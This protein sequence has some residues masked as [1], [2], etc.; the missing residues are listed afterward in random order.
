MKE[1]QAQKLKNEIILDVMSLI[2]ERNSII[3]NRTVDNLKE[4]AK[5]YSTNLKRASKNETILSIKTALKQFIRNAE[6]YP[7]TINQLY[8][9][10]I[11]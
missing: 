5:H 6:G 2:E 1:G 3:G 9:A 10:L 8:N 4:F 11:K 7:R